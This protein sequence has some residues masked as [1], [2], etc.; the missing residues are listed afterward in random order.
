MLHHDK[1]AVTRFVIITGLIFLP[2]LP[3][4]GQ[5]D[6]LSFWL[7][8]ALENNTVIA[9]A[10]ANVDARKQ[11]IRIEQSLPDPSFSGDFMITPAELRTGTREASTGL[12]QMVPWPGKLL[13]QKAIAQKEYEIALEARRSAEAKVL[14]DVRRVYA[15]YYSIGKEI[16]ISQD[17]LKLLQEMEKV[18]VAHY[19]TAMA[20]QVSLL[21]IQIEMASLEDQIKSLF[22]DKVT[23]QEKAILLLNVADNTVLPTPAHL[24]Q[25][26]VPAYAD[27]LIIH[28]EMNNPELIQARSEADAASLQ[29]D[30]AKQNFA[31]DLMLSTGYTF[32][33]STV[34]MESGKYPWAAGASISIPI[35]TSS[36]IARISEARARKEMQRANVA[37][38]RNEIVTDSKTLIEEYHD[39]Q[40]KI[41]LYME[42]LI[43]QS[44]RITSLV[45][46]SY[47]SGKATILDFLDAQ[48]MQ[49]DLQV[50]LE[51]QKARKEIIAGSI[52]MLL[53]GKLTRKSIGIHE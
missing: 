24:P 26:E 53:G 44:Q 3:A 14:A 40:R 32:G 34:P 46:E 30:L 37:G 4:C 10:K 52:D 16:G 21:K 49:L 11:R 6:S 35:W 19:A 43:P 22:A 12:S 33:K 20:P 8:S 27:S 51:K 45:Q 17:N 39:A 29:V 31:P 7:R 18:L 1:I 2:V 23:I 5:S 41:N 50:M 48:R 38:I 9:A 15:E 42:T 25:L 36:K 28:A 13:T 47:I